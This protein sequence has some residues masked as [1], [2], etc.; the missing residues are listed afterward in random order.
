[1]GELSCETARRGTCSHSAVLTGP[2]ESNHSA[3]SSQSHSCSASLYSPMWSRTR[4]RAQ[5]GA[6]SRGKWW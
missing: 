4:L 2:R 6:C 3:G 1:M 5:V